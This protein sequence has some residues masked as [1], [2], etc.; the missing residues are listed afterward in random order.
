MVLHHHERWDGNGYPQGLK[1]EEIPLGARIIHL[2]NAYDAMT[3]KRVY[4]DRMKPEEALEEIKRLAGS[5]FDPALVEA[6]I[7]GIS[8]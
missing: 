1:G 2:A 6:F 8:G 3:V 4:R 7:K 5:Q